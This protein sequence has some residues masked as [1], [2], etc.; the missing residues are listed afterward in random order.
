MTERPQNARTTRAYANGGGF[1]TRRSIPE[2]RS[3]ESRADE[4]QNRSYRGNHRAGGQHHLDHQTP[5]QQRDS[6]VGRHHA[7]PHDDYIS[8]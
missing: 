3:P 7:D 5:A 8:S 2:A 4:N 1:N 6:R